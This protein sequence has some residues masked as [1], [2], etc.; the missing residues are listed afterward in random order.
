MR[1][2]T[3]RDW[4]WSSTFTDRVCEVLR[5]NSFQLISIRPGTPLEDLKAATDMV[6]EVTAGT[7]AVRIRRANYGYR[8]LTIRAWRSSGAKTE[9]QKIQEG[10]A[11]YY[12]YA[13]EN[14]RGDFTDWMIVD[15]DCLRGSG[16]LESTKIK[17][18]RDGTTGFIC[19]NWLELY[20]NGCIMA[21]TMLPKIEAGSAW[22]VTV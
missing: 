19:I 5:A 20:E 13:W 2:D 12:L 6:V 3:R 8:D 16:L 9:L 18:N 10:H 7:I 14:E 21:T 11:D 1:A 4:N 22:R 17:K 15:L